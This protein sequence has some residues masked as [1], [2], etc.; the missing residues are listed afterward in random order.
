MV[1]TKAEQCSSVS[2]SYFALSFVS[3]RYLALAIVRLR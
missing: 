1:K 2:Q 3:Y